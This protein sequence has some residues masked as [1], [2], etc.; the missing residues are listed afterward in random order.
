MRFFGGVGGVFGSTFSCV[1]LAELAVGRI[2]RDR[3]SLAGAFVPAILVRGLGFGFCSG[4]DAGNDERGALV[5]MFA[6]VGLGGALAPVALFKV[7]GLDGFAVEALLSGRGGIVLPVFAEDEA[8]DAVAAPGRRTGRVGDLGLGLT[9][10]GERGPDRLGI[11][12]AA[13]PL[14]LLIAG[15]A[16]CVAFVLVDRRLG[17]GMVCF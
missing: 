11:P 2:M 3:K 12:V 5:R 8:V 4:V 6:A 13:T 15:R 17:L 1:L 16:D 14:G 9:T 10:L 7:D